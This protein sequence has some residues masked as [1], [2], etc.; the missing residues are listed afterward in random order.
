MYHFREY[1]VDGGLMSY[2][3]SLSEAF[4]EVGLYAAKILNG[5]AARAASSSALVLALRKVSG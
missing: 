3:T 4:R 2:G 5:A 1:V